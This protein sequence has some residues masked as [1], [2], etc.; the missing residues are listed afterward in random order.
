MSLRLC[1]EKAGKLVSPEDGE[2]LLSKAQE[3]VK[4][5]YDADRAA[6]MSVTFFKDEA[7][8]ALN[9]VYKQIGLPEIDKATGQP[10]V[11]PPPPEPPP[12]PPRELKTKPTETV[13]PEAEKPTLRAE[14]QAKAAEKQSEIDS[15]KAQLDAIAKEVGVPEWNP[16]GPES[17]FTLNPLDL[18]G[19][20]DR[21]QIPLLAQVA[22][23]SI[24]AGALK[25]ADFSLFIIENLGKNYTPF[26]ASLYEAT[27]NYFKSI[28]ENFKLSDEERSKAKTTLDK[29]TPI[30][31]MADEIITMDRK[32]FGD[33]SVKIYSPD[34]VI[35]VEDVDI[36]SRGT[37]DRSAIGRNSPDAE[38]LW[39]ESRQREKDRLS[40]LSAR[41]AEATPPLPAW[42]ELSNYAKDGFINSLTKR[43]QEKIRTKQSEVVEPAFFVPK[44][45]NFD[46]LS[47]QLLSDSSPPGGK[48]SNSL[49]YRLV[50]ILDRATG[51][52]H[53]VSVFEN[54]RKPYVTIF[55]E[56]VRPKGVGHKE[57]DRAV[58]LKDVLAQKD[59]FAAIGSI[60]TKGLT[61]YYHEVFADQKTYRDTFS[62]D[63]SQRQKAVEAV[64]RA[65]Q[66]KM[67][68]YGIESGADYRERLD[69][70]ISKAE[71][72]PGDTGSIEAPSHAVESQIAERA[73]TLAAEPGTPDISE[74][75]M[76]EATPVAVEHKPGK[77]NLDANDVKVLRDEF[78][79]FETVDDLREMLASPHLLS[80]NAFEL[81]E[82]I[83]A[84]DV[85]FFRHMAEDGLEQ[86]LKDY[87]YTDTGKG[88]PLQQ[89]T[90]APKEGDISTAGSGREGRTDRPGTNVAGEQDRAGTT[91]GEQRTGEAGAGAG[92]AIPDQASGVKFNL[93]IQNRQKRWNDIVEDLH[94]RFIK[95][96]IEKFNSGTPTERQDIL[97]DTIKGI[98]K[99]RDLLQISEVDK[100]LPE[101]VSGISNYSYGY[102]KTREENST[103][104]ALHESIH[105]AQS[106]AS[107]LIHNLIRDR[108]K[109]GQITDA[110]IQRNIL[111]LERLNPAYIRQQLIDF[112]SGKFKSEHA[113][114]VRENAA[115]IVLKEFVPRLA[116]GSLPKDSMEY[117]YVKQFVETVYG[118]KFVDFLESASNSP[119]YMPL[120]DSQRNVYFNKTDPSART[121]SELHHEQLLNSIH[122]AAAD[123]GIDVS[124]SKG[125]RSGMYD[126]ANRT[127]TQ[128]VGETVGRQ[129][130]K[131]AFHEVAHD[132]FA[133]EMP[134]VQ[135]SILKAI[136]SLSDRA[137][138]VD[139]SSDPRIRSDDPSG[140]GRRAVNEE[141]LVEATA[142]RLVKEGFD[143]AEAKGFAQRFVRAL[144]D[145]YY[146]AVMEVQKMFKQ[147]VNP[148]L[149]R[150]Y[151]ENRVR[152]LLSGD[153]SRTSYQ[154]WLRIGK[155]SVAA[156]QKEWFSRREFA[157]R[158]DN[159][160]VVYDH[161]PDLSLAASR[162]NSDSIKYNLPEAAPLYTRT[163]EIE[164]RVAVLNHLDEIQK[165]AAEAIESNPELKTRINSSKKGA[166]EWMRSLLKLSDPKESLKELEAWKETGGT[167]VQYDA[168]KTI[169]GFKGKSN[170]DA[171]LTK[172]FRNAQAFRTRV[173]NAAHNAVDAIAILSKKRDD[174][175]ERH[176]K[177][178]KEYKD[179]EGQTT[180]FRRSVFKDV[181]DLFNSIAGLSKKSGVIEQQLKS[182]DPTRTLKDYAPVF[183]NL[184]KNNALGDQKLFDLLDTAANDATIDFTKPVNEVRD[185]MLA[186]HVQSGK[187]Y[188]L[189]LKDTPD[190]KALLATVVAFA[191]THARTM[192]EL[193][194]RRE[195]SGEKRAEIE[196]KLAELATR[197]KAFGS[198]LR[199]LSKTAKLEERARRSY[200]ESVKRMR[201]VDRAIAREKSKID[202]A[203]SILPVVESEVARLTGKLDAS[204]DF[205]FR[206]GAE[207]LAAKPG[208]SSADVLERNKDGSLKN[209]NKLTLDSTRK[210]TDPRVVSDHLLGMKEWIDERDSAAKNGDDSAHDSVYQS[211]KRSYQELAAHIHY[212]LAEE[213]S[214]RWMLE[215]A[216]MPVFKRLREAFGTP[217]SQ[218]VD[219]IGNLYER[220]RSTLTR[221][222]VKVGHKTM[223]LEDEIL[224]LA[225]MTRE[226]LR[227]DILNPAKALLQYRTRD[228]A[229]T[230]AGQ[231]EKI[232]RAAYDR[233]RSMLLSN[234]ATRDI[235]SGNI[236][237][238]MPSLE[239]LIEHQHEAN[240]RQIAALESG[241]QVY[242]PFTGKY[243]NSGV[244]VLD[245]KLKVFNPITG[246]ME[247]AIRRHVDVGP[248][249]F[250]QRMHRNFS[251]M[252]NALRNSDW[253]SFEDVIGKAKPETEN[254]PAEPGLL[255]KA[256]SESPEAARALV[257]KFLN[258]AEHG[259]QVKESFFRAI[260][261]M[262][263]EAGFESPVMADKV[264]RPPADPEL[265]REAIDASGTH[266][267]VGFAERLFDLHN[268]EG[269]KADYVQE[270]AER[271][272]D[273]FK[274]AD[275]L[276]RQ[277][278]PGLKEGSVRAIRGM[279]PDAMINA[280]EL[281]NL[282]G[283]WFDY[284]DFDQ[285]DMFRMS[286]RIA[287][288]IAFGR[289]QE[290]LASLVDTI[291]KES[292]DARLKLETERSKVKRSNPSLQDRKVEEIVRKNLGEG[293]QKLKNFEKRQSLVGKSAIQLSDYFRR[294]YS[295]EGTLRTMTRAG[296]FLGNLM[297]NNPGSAIYQMAQLFDTVFRYGASPASLTTTGTAIKR[298]VHESVASLAQAVGIQM[299]NGSEFHERYVRLGLNDPAVANRFRD[300]FDRWQGE[301][302]GAFG[303]R[304]ASEI[305]QAGI[306]PLGEASQHTVLRPAGIFSMSTIIADRA[307]T[308][309]IW[310][311]VERFVAKGLDYYKDNT[312]KLED[313]T[314]SLSHDDLGLSNWNG[315]RAS[316]E[317]LKKDMERWGMNYDDMVRGAARRSDK[318]IITDEE[319]MR[320]HS[321][322]MSEISSQANLATMTPAAWNNSVI[323][324]MVPLLGWS[325]RRT[326]DVS[327]KR[328]DINGKMSAKALAQGMAALAVISTGGLALSAL[329]DQYYEDI[330]GKKRNL[331]PILTPG[332]LLE[333]SARLGQTGLFGELANGALNVGTGGD[334][335]IVSLDRRVVAVSAFMT[336]QS[337]ISAMVNQGEADYAHVVRPLVAAMGGG[338][339]LQ[340][341]QMANRAFGL[342]NVE[343]QINMRMNA[344]NYLRVVGRQLELDVRSYGGGAGYSN[345][346][347]MSPYLTRMELAAYSDDA[348]SFRIAYNEAI[349]KAKAQ[350]YPDP[351]D[352][353]KRSFAAKNPLRIAFQTSPSESDY[354][355][356]LNALPS[357]GR[358]DVSDA[359]DQFNRY[360]ESIGA[361]GFEGKVEKSASTT[362]GKPPTMPASSR[363]E[364]FRRQAV[365]R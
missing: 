159:G 143:P 21:R 195:K 58:S 120:F 234:K 272:N 44:Q 29:M 192:T 249:T 275:T 152:Q 179:Y 137:L 328:L 171:V 187:P 109:N 154:E 3:L 284:H 172:A 64:A 122:A 161:E 307:L 285:R 338:G 281:E 304:A 238:I 339:A 178:S 138:G 278:N 19:I 231:P 69:E 166:L 341:M 169:E 248:W 165:R 294:D 352:Q 332:G 157:E 361:R 162:F 16:S 155:P 197:K 348:V 176:E 85:Y 180:Q 34:H 264:T 20:V 101:D 318:T 4:D 14:I 5:G 355:R 209:L 242:N 175:R 259:D 327:S 189:L 92:N 167:P 181:K 55:D 250:S 229:E 269:S 326:L 354:K 225:P 224:K 18:I 65:E 198:E 344:Q 145:F 130:V 357:D 240:K 292:E 290:R 183:E 291:G 140:L 202:A 270:I 7:L 108:L 93:P 82:K 236:E 317:R 106:I 13:K 168:A 232:R 247:A 35:K 91:E 128:V 314:H 237:K 118:K 54:N 364:A 319:A 121:E 323:R 203:E 300:S 84:Q 289:G 98:L 227:E 271:M 153:T 10:V 184:V 96:T 163:N 67:E 71:I 351:V 342:D 305:T 228:I 132:V 115:S 62:R 362:I 45:K 148:E 114:I 251:L 266:D 74:G 196:D 76:S 158:F 256:Y 213:P 116:D 219:R 277:N 170:T 276:E 142:E 244:G 330:L 185:A 134:E 22:K 331:R 200:F 164:K 57:T 310:K 186:S 56:S 267:L 358:R 350:G 333:H 32:M 322:A 334:N 252:L 286:E 223:Q 316:F 136:D 329:V 233:V 99:S 283:S 226:R 141:R 246:K 274:Q 124:T 302:A 135:D 37:R 173:A 298:A 268:A 26:I 38:A 349:A 25:F 46:K 146:K 182:L 211:V 80:D 303:L 343:A 77:L 204:P 206:D 119:D 336:V 50:D 325:I 160:S 75:S 110:D 201:Q 6:M 230:Y 301:S 214:Q 282:P 245:P 258:H 147:S 190:S 297:V 28:A 42:S 97:L 313:A 63:V 235:V 243:E 12:A 17:G 324:F 103:I 111:I 36:E 257:N 363:M 66:Q 239:R 129:D 208:M 79:G 39:E 27:R 117:G 1:I 220:V 261:E 86:T 11:P 199:E 72:N 216:F 263:E 241:I 105:L 299:G 210:A 255:A 52:V 253:A 127:L 205:V 112:I 365:I 221:D 89:G 90:A 68:A 95:P 174:M 359:V 43:Q 356:I 293:Y 8:D 215:L 33:R 309:G 273:Y 15:I 131:T 296:Q 149:A 311:L 320:L 48:Y 81:I 41:Q 2:L 262:P 150:R 51:K 61:E 83:A 156:R 287:S 280:R 49:T 133:R 260:A 312:S 346:T 193:E 139:T 207:Y 144:K 315:D 254:T 306:N 24:E 295:P 218:A 335:R 73:G 113:D 94:R 78:P 151:F 345:V 288:E 321:M 360:A 53:R 31:A 87:G 126:P 177:Q 222:G 337:A 308:D 194:L 30:D 340:Y 104:T 217:A 107:G 60:R 265:V 100:S 70:S 23:L 191:K 347:P 40:K 102:L 212:N 123:A 88:K 47:K 188:D 59:R 279:T 9:S 353:V 125:V